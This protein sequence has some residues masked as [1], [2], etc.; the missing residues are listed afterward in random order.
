MLEITKDMLDQTIETERKNKA[1]SDKAVQI[2]AHIMIAAIVA[3]FVALFMLLH[4][5]FW[6]ALIYVAI[7]LAVDFVVFFGVTILISKKYISG[8][9]VRAFVRG[10]KNQKFNQAVEAADDDTKIRLYEERLAAVK[11][12]EKLLSINVL[13]PMY[14][15][16]NENDKA[17]ALLKEAEDI[18]PKNFWQKSSRALNYLNFYG[19]V[20]DGERFIR[21]YRENEVVIEKMWNDMLILKIEALKYTAFFLAYSGQYDKAIEYYL[22]VVEFQEKAG[23]IDASCGIN[24][25]EKKVVDIDLAELYCKSGNKEKSAEYFREAKEFFA[26]TDVPFLRS[27]L[28]RVGKI[29][30]EAGICY[31]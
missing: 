12:G 2:T 27:E 17:E 26:D 29:L 3:E 14:L 18:V 1:A 4:N 6:A 16:I 31:S 9:T 20:N 23:E 10:L 5:S 24:E 25:E 21:A 7:I 8:F 28:E 13:I 19:A 22:N 30:D 15:R 11:G